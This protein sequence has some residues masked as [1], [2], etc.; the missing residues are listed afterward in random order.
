MP[1]LEFRSIALAHIDP[2]IPSH[3]VPQI[4]QGARELEAA[5]GSPSRTL[6]N[7][8]PQVRPW[9]TT[10][11]AHNGSIA[12]TRPYNLLGNRSAITVISAVQGILDA[13]GTT[14][15]V[16]YSLSYL[17]HITQ[18]LQT[19]LGSVGPG[20]I[21]LV[22]NEL[23]LLIAASDRRYDTQLGITTLAQSNDAVLRA[24]GDVIQPMAISELVAWGGIAD[25]R[26]TLS[27]GT[28]H[29][30]AAT[31][32]VPGLPLA[33]AVLTYDGDWTGDLTTSTR[34]TALASAGILLLSIATMVGVTFWMVRPLLV[35]TNY[36]T[37]FGTICAADAGPASEAG[38]PG[39]TDGLTTKERTEALYSR[40]RSAIDS[41]LHAPRARQSIR[42][43]S[44]VED[45]PIATL[46]VSQ[47]QGVPHLPDRSDTCT[48]RVTEE[49]GNLCRSFD[50]MLRQWR[51]M[52]DVLEHQK[53]SKRQ[54][55]RYVF[56]EVRV[57]LNAIVLAADQLDHSAMSPDVQDL[58]GILQ[59]QSM[60]VKR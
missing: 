23:G 48:F 44:A 30:A 31:I 16:A 22:L 45:V 18:L 54:F 24:V 39:P 20:G 4:L 46:Q 14:V 21:V 42:R 50:V 12:W 29:L 10:A 47:K 56:H 7:Y 5:L 11:V 51:D 40:W 60:F 27:G 32:P 25:K 33:V 52:Y 17:T 53:E 34:N 26:I 35:L 55:I 37:Q 38:G 58:V 2:L 15:A 8:R 59:E 9:F 49:V 36:M 43:P 28:Y 19:Q 3:G 6:A 41:V 1:E 13:N 57:P